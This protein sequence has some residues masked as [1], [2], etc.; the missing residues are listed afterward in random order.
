M[1]SRIMYDQLFNNKEFSSER[2]RIPSLYT[3]NND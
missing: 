1:T 3:L 2:N